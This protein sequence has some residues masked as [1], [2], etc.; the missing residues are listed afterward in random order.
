MARS[1]LVGKQELDAAVSEEQ[2]SAVLPDP[3]LCGN[4]CELGRSNGDWRFCIVINNYH[5]DQRTGA[6]RHFGRSATGPAVG[7]GQ[8]GAAHTNTA[9]L[10]FPAAVLTA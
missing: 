10:R 9:A 5:A 6:C 3:G 8:R 7:G 4:G 1:G 2:R